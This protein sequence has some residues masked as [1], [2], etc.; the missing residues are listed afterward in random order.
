MPRNSRIRVAEHPEIHSS[1]A[2]YE[3]D[4]HVWDAHPVAHEE[5]K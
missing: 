3:P 5:H 4:I 2:E 1:T